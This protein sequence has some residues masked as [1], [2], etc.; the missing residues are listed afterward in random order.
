MTSRRAVNGGTEEM[1][2]TIKTA[3]RVA[4]LAL[5]LAG[6]SSTTNDPS[7][8]YPGSGTDS[9]SLPIP[10]LVVSPSVEP[11]VDPWHPFAADLIHLQP[12]ATDQ[13][14]IIGL[15]HAFPDTEGEVIVVNLD[16]P[17]QRG[18]ALIGPDGFTITLGGA[19]TDRFRLLG[20][21]PTFAS[22]GWLQSDV[23]LGSEA[24]I[25]V[26]VEQGD[27][28][29]DDAQKQLSFDELAVGQQAEGKVRIDNRCVAAVELRDPRA[30]GAQ[31]VAE[32]EPFA[33]TI[34]SPGNGAEL[35]VVFT[36][37]VAGDTLEF[38]A[39]DLGPD[40]PAFVVTVL[41]SAVDPAPP[42]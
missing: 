19:P 15:P 8:G 23:T 30:L 21:S 36:P 12:A 1:L 38:V 27:C 25:A 20:R 40:H 9:P 13:T 26:D 24:D 11:L 22:F 28:L 2:V 7:Q 10:P 35:T 3:A 32:L 34:L 31:T 17:D 6:C 14:T 4:G 37:D 18:Q 42:N 33:P 5:V 39:V 41:G 16:R 29:L